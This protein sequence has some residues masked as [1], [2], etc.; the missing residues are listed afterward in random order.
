MKINPHFA[1]NDANIQNSFDVPA[2]RVAVFVLVDSVVPT[3]CHQ[4]RQPGESF[5]SGSWEPAP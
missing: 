3:L 1:R 2:L 4:V 5:K